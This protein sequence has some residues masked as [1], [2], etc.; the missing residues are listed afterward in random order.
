MTSKADR[1]LPSF[2]KP[3]LHEVALS[4]QFESLAELTVAHVGQFWRDVRDRF[5]LVEEQPALPPLAIERGGARATNQELF[6]TSEAPR[7]RLWL[8]DSKKRELVQIQHDRFIRNWR[9]SGL[10]E[11]YP[12]YEE[13]IRPR[14]KSDYQAFRDFVSEER[15]GEVKALQCEVAYFNQIRISDRVWVSFK[16]MH[17]VFRFFPHAELEAMPL[18]GEGLQLRQ[19]FAIEQQEEF[20]GRIYTEI[21]PTEVDGEPAIRYQ[22]TARGHTGSGSV[23]DTLAFLDLGREL[24]VEFFTK[25]TSAAMHEVWERE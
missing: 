3:P 15:L 6:I 1:K 19:S 22:L 10:D 24:I 2:R 9:K 20:R 18:S 25:S 12:R 4:V 21:L 7:P 5:P 11:R 17:N 14:F 23:E 8:L 13:H 16:D